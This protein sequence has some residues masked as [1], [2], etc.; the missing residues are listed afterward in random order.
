MYWSSNL[1]FDL[2]VPIPP[3]KQTNTLK[4]AIQSWRVSAVWLC[5]S[6][7]ETIRPCQQVS[8]INFP[9]KIKSFF[10]LQLDTKNRNRHTQLA[11]LPNSKIIAIINSWS[12]TEK[13]PCIHHLAAQT[14]LLLQSTSW[15]KGL[16]CYLTQVH[17]SKVKEETAC[18]WSH[19]R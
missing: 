14:T 3:K 1:H 10:I 9:K 4:V 2:P 11:E 13:Q 7:E 5:K 16:L 12:R 15:G 6:K 17:Q 18:L 8:K 19:S